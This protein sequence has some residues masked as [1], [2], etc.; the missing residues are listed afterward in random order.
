MSSG[1]I[2]FPRTKKGTLLKI[3]RHDISAAKIV[4]FEGRELTLENRKHEKRQEER[5]NSE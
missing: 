4:V 1:D 3:N 5:R 2:S